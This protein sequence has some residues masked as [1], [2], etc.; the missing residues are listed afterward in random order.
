VL[1]GPAAADFLELEDGQHCFQAKTIQNKGKF[2]FANKV[3]IM[4]VSC[5][6]GRAVH[7]IYEAANI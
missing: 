4:H 2:P 1:K 3:V 7:V 6:L 5:F